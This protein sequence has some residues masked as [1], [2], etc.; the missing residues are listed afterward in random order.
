MERPAEI[1]AVTF[2][3]W[4]GADIG[5]NH[6]RAV[7]S[8][9]TV[10]HETSALAPGRV[11]EFRQHP[12]GMKRG[13]GGGWI[14][15]VERMQP[16]PRRG[17]HRGNQLRRTVDSLK[18]EPVLADKVRVG[19]VGESTVRRECQ[20]AVRR[21]LN[22]PDSNVT[23]GISFLK[24]TRR[25][26][27][28]SLG[29]AEFLSF[30]SRCRGVL[31]PHSQWRTGHG[32]GDIRRLNADSEGF[33]EL[34]Q[35]V[36]FYGDGNHQHVRAGGKYLRKSA[37]HDIIRSGVDRPPRGPG[38]QRATGDGAGAGDGCDT[39]ALPSEAPEK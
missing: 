17:I 18:T 22:K 15:A 32:E 12:G 9:A 36:C 14:A 20:R 29:R 21:R 8:Y 39:I 3:G 13:H 31:D 10:G 33:P 37:R 2:P 26:Q 6:L 5:I 19:C 7:R 4:R 1:G 24:K 38:Y 34:I 25:R 35:C 11:I 30:K 27:H 23:T 16:A 28:C